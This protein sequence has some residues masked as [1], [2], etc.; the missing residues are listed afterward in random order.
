MTDAV[1]RIVFM[2]TPEFAVATLDAIVKSGADVVAVVTVPDKPAGRGQKLSVS[3][4]KEYANNN[5][6][7]VLQPEK[8]RDEPF[9]ERLKSFNADIF[10][11]VAF[12]MLPEQVWSIPRLGTFNAHASLL[13]QYRGA[14]P[15]NH[16]IIN[17]ETET[18]VT[19][20]LLD[21][22]IDTGNILLTEKTPINPMDTAGDLHDRLMMIAADITVKT[23]NGLISKTI[24]P[25]PQ[26]HFATGTKLNNAPKLFP[27][28]SVIKWNRSAQEIHNFIR[29]LSPYPGARTVLNRDAEKL[30]LK[31][32]GSRPY[33]QIIRPG[34][35]VATSKG[36]LFIG[37]C[38]GSVE[39]TSL[40][41]EGRRRMPASEFLKGFDIK[42]WRIS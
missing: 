19:T 24:E 7:E 29:G 35:I 14:A 42:K 6:I 12:R 17:G 3:P 2:G 13:P 23:I 32:L 28:D 5:N 8:L 22:N 27:A 25:K 1:P 15:I 20:F 33:D 31:I 40:Q 18:G 11:I 30:T 4:V 21:K 9:I 26:E 16:V 38:N 34:D 39:I 36:G 37:C 41:A 10:V